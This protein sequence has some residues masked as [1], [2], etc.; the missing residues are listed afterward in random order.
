MVAVLVYWVDNPCDRPYGKGILDIFQDG[1]IFL[2]QSSVIKNCFF[3]YREAFLTA[4]SLLKNS[5]TPHCQRFIV[6]VTDGQDRDF[7]QR[8]SAGL[9][10]KYTG[11]ENFR[12]STV[13]PELSA[14]LFACIFMV[15]KIGPFFFQIKHSRYAYHLRSSQGSERRKQTFQG[16]L[17]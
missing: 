1:E 7:T 14:N 8:C 5:S 12:G 6:F 2:N 15:E 3:I 13:I 17:I 16:L 4:F 10:Y 9:H 11:S